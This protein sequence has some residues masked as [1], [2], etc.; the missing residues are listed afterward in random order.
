MT[1]TTT[2]EVARGF[3][4]VAALRPLWE[5]F[6]RGSLTADFDHF[7]AVL[8]SEQSMLEPWTLTAKRDGAPVAFAVA[9]LEDIKLPLRIGYRTLASPGLRSLTVV[10]RGVLGDI[11]D[12][13]AA[14][15]VGALSG[16]LRDGDA[17]VATFRRLE[18][19]SPLYEAATTRPG[20]LAR[21]HRAR[22]GVAWERS[23]PPSYDAFL[24]S[25]SKQSRTGLTRYARKLERD[26][27]GRL[28]VRRVSRPDQ[29]D[30]YFDDAEAVASLTYQRGLGVGVRDDDAHRRRTLLSLEKGWFR[31]IVLRLDDRPVA[32]CNG[33]AYGG[34]FAYG[35]PGYDPAYRDYRV[36]NYVL[37]KL[38]E[39]LCA[40]PDVSVLDFGFGD[41]EYKRR[42]GDRSWQEADVHVFAARARPAT[43]NV[44][45][46][47]VLS[48]NDALAWVA[49]SL[50]VLGRV[51][52]RWRSSVSEGTG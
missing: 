39:D 48:A 33:E 22:S 1:S 51:K 38:I 49:R 34:R 47:A 4:E 46:T 42:F 7:H 35:I 30:E 6:P 45:R 15:L 25:L 11:D 26:F 24:A 52:Q 16:V 5:S 41:A 13:L 29:L 9:R 23:L 27:D 10:Y 37:A 28:E 32:F 18:L 50:G 2:V 12:D 21:Q 19:G 8:A 20:L 14:A 17:D 3:D 43:V 40:D 31:A 36:G 44:A